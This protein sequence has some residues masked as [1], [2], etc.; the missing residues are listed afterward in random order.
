MRVL[1]GGQPLIHLHLPPGGRPLEVYLPGVKITVEY[2]FQ[3]RAVV[4]TQI[5]DMT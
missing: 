1:L 3:G 2:D 4:N 5:H